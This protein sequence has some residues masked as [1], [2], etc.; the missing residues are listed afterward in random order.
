MSKSSRDCG[1]CD[2]EGFVEDGERTVDTRLVLV[3]CPTCRG[4]GE[5]HEIAEEDDEGEDEEGNVLHEHSYNGP[6]ADP[7]LDD[8]SRSAMR[9][10]LNHYGLPLHCATLRRRGE[11]ILQAHPR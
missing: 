11:G 8:R 3:R 6:F 2:G 7:S 5:S 10:I 4:T 1:E 9:A